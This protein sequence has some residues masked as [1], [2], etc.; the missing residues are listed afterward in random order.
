MA[1]PNPNARTPGI[2]DAAFLT[3]V[4]DITEV[5]LIRHGQQQV[6]FGGPVGSA[7][8]P[9]LS[10]R[11]RMQAELLGQALSTRRIDAIYASHLLRAQQT[12][13]PIAKHQGGMAITIVEDLREVEIFREVPPDQAAVEF[14]GRAYMNGLRQRMLTEKSWD[15]YPHSESSFDFRK[16]TINAIEGIIADHEG[17]RVAVV[18]HGGVI[19]AYAGHVIGTRFDMFFRPAHTSLSIVAAAQE[20]RALHLLNDVHHLQAGEAHLHTH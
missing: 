18:C 1:E 3:G 2:F 8:D 9:P 12:A 6:D 7:I 10:E 13:A 17:Q 20:R 11:G 14:V 5:L 15:V 16:R 19:N 4:P